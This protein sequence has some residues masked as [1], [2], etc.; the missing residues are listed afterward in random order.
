MTTVAEAQNSI[1]SFAKT[2]GTESVTLEK[3]FGRILTPPIR[4]DRDYPPFN[5]SMMDGYAV[6]SADFQA[7]KNRSLPVREYIHAGSVGE[8][9]VISGT[10]SKIMTGAPL[11]AGADAVVRVEDTHEENGVVT[12]RIEAIRAGQHIAQRGEDARHGE[13]LLGGNQWITPPIV[14]V[15]A[16]TGNTQVLVARLPRIGIISTGN[17]IVSVSAPILPHQIRDSNAWALRGLLSTYQITDVATTLAVDDK[18]TMRQSIAGFLAEKDII[19]LSGGVS[20][21]DADYVPEVLQS[22]G[23]QQVFHRVRIKPGGPLWFGVTTGGKAVFGLPG[24]PVSV[25]VAGKLFIEPYLRMCFG[26]PR[27]FPLGLPFLEN[28]TKKTPFDEFFP[29]QLITQKGR[30]GVQPVRYNSSGD[31]TAT[32]KSNG[33]AWQPAETEHLY[34]DDLVQFYEW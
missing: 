29:C 19:L 34:P 24:N 6:Q 15:L 31:S 14:S 12:F 21:G 13:V 16:L 10:C 30:T 8:Q 11:P 27:L 7:D 3:S 18:A 28:R 1:F 5:R 4:A 22:L 17:E 20:R 32:A 9:T 23:V 26:L 2:F 25:Q 33:I